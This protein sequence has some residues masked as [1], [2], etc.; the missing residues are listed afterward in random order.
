MIEHLRTRENIRGP[1]LVV[2]PL[3]TIGHWEREV[4]GWTDMTLCK[5][6]DNAVGREV[7]REHEWYYDN[8]GG[9][10]DVIKFNV[11]VTT[12]EVRLV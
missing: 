11:M 8:V 12:Y 5:Y 7:I 9:R 10:R 4:N 2:A 6:Y 1:F 3:S